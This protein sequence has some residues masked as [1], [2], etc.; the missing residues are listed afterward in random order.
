MLVNISD[1]IAMNAVPKYILLSVAMPSTMTK[2][3]MKDLANGFE[4]MAKKY[5]LEIIGE[6]TWGSHLKILLKYL[7]F[8]L[9]L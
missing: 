4:D 7:I 3:D 6:T 2:D 1:A 5:N 9:N 8:R